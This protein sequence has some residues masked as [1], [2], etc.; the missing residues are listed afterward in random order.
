VF[1]DD[2]ASG[3][4]AG[5]TFATNLVI[6]GARGAPAAPSAR[7]APSGQ[8]AYAYRELGAGLTSVCMSLRV[9]LQAQ[10]GTGVDLARLRTA[11]GGPVAK[12][13]V[14]TTGTLMIRSDFAGTQRSSGVALGTGWHA[15]ELCG[16]VGAA[17]TWTL[18][19]DG[20][21]IVNAWQADVGTTP[22]GRVQ[23]GDTAS[24]TWTANF[25]DVAVET[26]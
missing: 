24:K 3:S 18:S 23:I 22:V 16:S 9:D 20:I 2:F 7:G 26:S 11:G 1:G 15:I 19:R 17:S 8:A 25:D 6:D 12:V 10:Q 21:V 14:N 13:F 5:W 4:L